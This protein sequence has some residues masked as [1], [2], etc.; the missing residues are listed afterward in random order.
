VSASEVAARAKP[1]AR[2]TPSQWQGSSRYRPGANALHCETQGGPIPN[3]E[4]HPPGMRRT[5]TAASMAELF[6]AF[7]FRGA[8]DA[9]P[10]PP[11]Q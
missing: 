9:L 1:L 5:S 4:S 6:F 10:C 2:P 7:P 3:S 11:F 8:A